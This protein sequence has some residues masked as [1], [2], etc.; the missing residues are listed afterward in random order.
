MINTQ[1]P[2]IQ[3]ILITKITA[4]L[5]KTIRKIVL[6]VLSRKSICSNASYLMA[7]ECFECSPASKN[8]FFDLL[9]HA[10]PS[11]LSTT[12]K[13]S[14]T[15]TFLLSTISSVQKYSSDTSC[16]PVHH[17]KIHKPDHC[18]RCQRNGI[19][20]IFSIALQKKI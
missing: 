2:Y 16:Q 14:R 18:I 1:I 3:N 13:T 17:C 7:A 8:K 20:Q 6:L 9:C 15:R 10:V 4:K 5:S 11:I 12:I 19:I